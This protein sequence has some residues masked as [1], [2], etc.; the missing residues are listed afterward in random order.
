ML[1]RKDI[2][3]NAKFIA[4]HLILFHF[5]NHQTLSKKN[6]NIALISSLSK[7]IASNYVLLD[8]SHSNYMNSPV[9][10]SNY[11]RN[12]LINNYQYSNNLSTQFLVPIISSLNTIQNNTLYI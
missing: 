5:S 6:I 8:H 3:K 12:Y 11:N 10:Y 9:R 7:L 2:S 1:S 4:S